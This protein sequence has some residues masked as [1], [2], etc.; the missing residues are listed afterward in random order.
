MFREYIF[1][2]GSIFENCYVSLGVS[3]LWKMDIFP[4]IFHHI[5]L[6]NSQLY[7]T[8]INMFLL[9]REHFQ[10]K[11]PSSNH[12]FSGANC[13]F[14]EKKSHIHL[15]K[16]GKSSTQMC[17]GKGRLW[18]FPRRS[19]F[20]IQTFQGT[21]KNRSPFQVSEWRDLST[22]KVCWGIWTCFQVGYLLILL[23][24]QLSNIIISILD[25]LSEIEMSILP[26]R[27]SNNNHYLLEMTITPRKTN[28]SPKRD[29]FKK[30]YIWNNHWFLGDIPWFSG[31]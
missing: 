30:K 29:Y 18:S 5:L 20:L 19:A 9:K 31:E 22:K 15:W 12:W 28:M 10:R 3:H 7:P 6:M 17:F 27:V 24:I 11:G 4:I 8:K 23:F 2:P 16:V 26:F 14:S 25:D 13:S 1:N 21:K